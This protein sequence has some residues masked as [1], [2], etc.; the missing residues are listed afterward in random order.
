VLLAWS[1]IM[2]RKLA[3][4]LTVGTLALVLIVL[5]HAAPQST[6][7]RPSSD[8]KW[9]SWSAETR[10]TFVAAYLDGYQSG[11]FNGCNAA[12]ELFEVGK[13]FS[14]LD[15]LPVRRCNRKAKHFSKETNDYISVLTDFY[16]RHPQFRNIPHFYLLENLIDGQYKTGDEIYQAALKGQIRTS[17]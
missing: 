17:F 11:T 1:D 13:T 6:P 8:D 3:A 10:A 15:D 9:L 7:R 12:G 14:N 2:T 4:F 5:T 16:T